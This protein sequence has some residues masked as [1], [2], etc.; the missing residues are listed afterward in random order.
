MKIQSDTEGVRL[1]EA[2]NAIDP[3]ELRASLAAMAE[4]TQVRQIRPKQ[5]KGIAVHN[6]AIAERMK[7]TY[8]SCDFE[9]LVEQCQELGVFD[10][11]VESTTGL[12][13]TAGSD[14]NWNMSRRTWVTDL[15]RCL[16]L[17]KR[18][19]SRAAANALIT[20]AMFYTD[21]AHQKMMEKA[22]ND[23]ASYRDG[24]LTDGVPHIFVPRRAGG[25]LGRLARWVAITFGHPILT[26]LLRRDPD[27]FNNKRLES[28]ALTL[29]ALCD[30]LSDS[31][32]GDT[33]IDSGLL[34]RAE[35]LLVNAIV[36]LAAYLKAVNTDPRTGDFD[37][38]APSSGNWEEVPFA[39]G[40]T[41]DTEAARAAFES[42]RQLLFGGSGQKEVALRLKVRRHKWGQWLA[43]RSVLDRLI[44]GAHT[45]VSERARTG[46]GGPM[47][48]PVRPMDASLSFV[49][50]STIR[51]EDGAF[52]DARH[53]FMLLGCL[54]SFLVRENGMVRYQ[55]YNMQHQGKS[56]LA[57]DSYLADDYWFA[58][59]LRALLHGKQD[60]SASQL[61]SAGSTD[62]SSEDDFINRQALMREGTEAQWCWVSVMAEGYARRTT[63]MI[64]QA[65]SGKKGEADWWYE[66]AYQLELIESGVRKASELINRSY[67][68]VT[69]S[70]D[71]GVRLKSNGMPCPPNAVP[72]AYESVSALDGG[73]AYLPGVNTPLAWGQASLLSAS[74][75]FHEMLLRYEELNAMLEARHEENS[76]LAEAT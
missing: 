9:A 67:A 3:S 48:H 14:E 74:E 4:A 49:S 22:I 28:A 11:E 73:R 20:L 71:E 42:L 7:P 32:A 66:P 43:D 65:L 27:W 45:R 8:R 51:F 62:C 72:E 16:N 35:D 59:A 56:V 17:L 5:V 10:I 34:A 50:T 46:D 44:G 69:P 1:H 38:Q 36:S 18:K 75:S 19:D 23:P 37:F 64:E 76:R 47:E 25:L 12:V 58:P 29:K 24:S 15:V 70:A 57:K 52:A 39:G 63:A 54:H 31:A 26:S 30:A 53:H 13:K 2:V 60:A 33:T 21:P 61:V 55:P 40:L 6:S 41:W 68:R